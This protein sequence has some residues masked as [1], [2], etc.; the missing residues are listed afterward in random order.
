LIE[1]VAT[2]WFQ[3]DLSLVSLHQCGCVVSL[4]SMT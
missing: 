4:M 1:L 2:L 3:T